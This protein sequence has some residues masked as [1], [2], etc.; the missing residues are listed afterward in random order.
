M[1]ARGARVLVNVSNDA[2]FGFGQGARQHFYMGTL[3][4]IETRRY[5]LRGGNDGVTA[6]VDPLGR[7][8]AELPRGKRGALTARYG[9]RTGITPYVRFG[10][11]LIAGLVLYGGVVV[12]VRR[13]L[14]GDAAFS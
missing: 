4:A 3:R 6:A 12:V 14:L 1:V 2:W 10:D 5:L 9:E 7:T 13:R 8:L 11:L